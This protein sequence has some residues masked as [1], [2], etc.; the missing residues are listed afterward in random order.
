MSQQESEMDSQSTSKT[1]RMRRMRYTSHST[2]LLVGQNNPERVPRDEPPSSYDA[3]VMQQ[4]Y[5]AQNPNTANVS[6]SSQAQV[7]SSPNILRLERW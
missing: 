1:P 2:L 5:Q 4:G 7:S 3:T 6:G